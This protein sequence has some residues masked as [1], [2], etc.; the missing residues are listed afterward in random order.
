MITQSYLGSSDRIRL[1]GERWNSFFL[2][3]CKAQY[4]GDVLHTTNS[5]SGDNEDTSRVKHF[6]RDK[7][8]AEVNGQ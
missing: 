1:T 5:H 3:L 8:P 2:S 6:Y 4:E 7:A